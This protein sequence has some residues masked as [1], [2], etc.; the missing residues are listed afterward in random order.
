M[1]AT[2]TA[3]GSAPLPAARKWS[4][5]LILFGMYVTFGMSWLGI[6]PV[7]KDILTVLKIDVASASSL[8]SIVSLAKSIVPIMAGVMAARW[9][10]TNT[11][12]LSG[13]LILIGLAVPFLPSY[14]LWIAT[15]FLFGV[16]G[17]IW[18][19][20]MG[21]VT[22]Q[23]F[24]AAQRPVI[25]AFN[26][27]AVNIGIILALQLTTP[28][29]AALG[30]K[31]TLA[32]YSLFSGFFYLALLLVGPL[33]PPPAQPHPSAQS[34][35]SGPRYLD[36]L[37]M[38]VTWLVSLA[39]CGPLALYLVLNYWLPIYFQ[40]VSWLVPV[41]QGVDEA[42]RKKMIKGE[43]NQLMSWLNL[44]GCVSS[45]A[46]G[47]LLQAFKKTR[48]FILAAAILLPV[49]SLLAL[50]SSNKGMLTL[51]LALT[52]VGMF[53]SVAPLV[54][55]LQSQPGMNPVLIG[56]IMGTMFSVTYILSAL[57]PELVSIGYKAHLPLQTLLMI[58][59]AITVSPA[60]GLMLPEK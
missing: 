1:T 37:K 43:I 2:A 14:P 26:G 4:I 42:V 58:C 13:G 50:Q 53:L 16:G 5:A 59:C 52:G 3:P 17:A 57:A 33:A 47:F 10:L 27:V 11:L 32:L 48:P 21:A 18:V 49:A 24:D 28:L 8:Y 45:I 54:T 55:L 25:N 9:G 51:M 60:I 40:E 29:S 46:T 30:W 34:G 22:L 23:I 6:V 36:T 56:M 35:H 19:S 44:W 38:P 31:Y 41:T 15:R 39:F 7:L 12:R 20:L